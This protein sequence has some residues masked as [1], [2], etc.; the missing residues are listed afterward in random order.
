MTR[1]RRVSAL[2]MIVACAH[3]A[4]AR[5]DSTAAP[6]RLTRMSDAAIAGTVA[7][8]NASEMDAARLARTR[9]SR[10]DVRAFAAQIERDHAMLQDSVLAGAPDAQSY[11]TLDA[12]AI[13][14]RGQ[15]LL[16]TLASLSGSAFD[17]AYLDAQVTDHQ[18]AL[19]SLIAWQSDARDAGLRSRLRTARPV[20][21]AHYD[22]AL[23]LLSALRHPGES[24]VWKKHLGQPVAASGRPRT[25]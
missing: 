13:R 21:Q 20:V 3:D 5:A 23:A 14:A 24:S 18:M 7:A 15:S 16:D 6:T 2:L 11:R 9:A 25:P 1:V 4:D 10:P 22:H 17:L 12:A 8:I 19:Q